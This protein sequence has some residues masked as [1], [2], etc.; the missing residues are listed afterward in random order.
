MK[1]GFPYGWSLLALLLVSCLKE[2]KF[3]TTYILKPSVQYQSV[4][5][6]EPLAGVVAYAYEVDTLDW[7]IASYDDAAAGII[8]RKDDPSQRLT[9]PADFAVPYDGTAGTEGAEGAEAGD[10][11]NVDRSSW[12]QMPLGRVPRMIVVVDPATRLYGY[13]MQQPLLNLPKLYVSV[14]FQPW[15]EG[16]AYKNGAW[17][18]YND[19][20]TPPTVLKAYYKPTWQAEADGEESAFTSSQVKAYAYVADTTD[21]Y[22]A[23]YDDAVAGKI[24]RKDESEERT[25]PNFQAYYE[26]D[27]G[28]YGM[29]VTATPLMSVVVDRLNRIYAYTKLVPDLEGPSPTWPVV[30]RPWR[31]E[32]KYK[33]NDWCM[34]DDRHAPEPKTEN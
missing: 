12:L 30:F 29:E 11:G 16:Y 34:V 25:T 14:V 28:T 24:T 5:P 13:T 31:T 26:S 1:R 15:K 7:G 33:E 4:D 20:Y 22:I 3:E 17:S 32:W 21:W 18:F 10:D 2:G 23:S 19:F 8:T 9:E 6:A 27:S